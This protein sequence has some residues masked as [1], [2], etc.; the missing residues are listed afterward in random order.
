MA[1]ERADEESRG[2]WTFGGGAMQQDAAAVVMRDGKWTKNYM[3]R[4]R[5][6]DEWKGAASGKHGTIRGVI[7]TPHCSTS[8]AVE[9]YIGVGGQAR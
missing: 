1:H 9:E 5:A 7:S 6:G 3:N 8:A 2:P 4:A